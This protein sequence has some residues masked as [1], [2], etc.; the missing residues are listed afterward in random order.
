MACCRPR[1]A[2]PLLGAGVYVVREPLAAAWECE[3]TAAAARLYAG[4]WL[5][6]VRSVKVRWKKLVRTSA[7]LC[8]TALLYLIWATRKRLVSVRE[9]GQG[10]ERT[11]HYI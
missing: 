6:L 3:V 4:L 1:V 5:R 2:L 10:I 11:K 9:R 7:S 8:R